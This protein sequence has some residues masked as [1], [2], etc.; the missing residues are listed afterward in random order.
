MDA[1]FMASKRK[2]FHLILDRMKES[3]TKE[4]ENYDDKKKEWNRNTHLFL[5]MTNIMFAFA[6]QIALREII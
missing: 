6:Y 2:S 3:T 1:G 5:F 4:K